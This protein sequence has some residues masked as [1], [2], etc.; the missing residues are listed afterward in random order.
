MVSSGYDNNDNNQRGLLFFF[1]HLI[2]SVY[3][4]KFTY[5]FFNETFKRCCKIKDMYST[6][7]Q[8]QII[9]WIVAKYFCCVIAIVH[10]VVLEQKNFWVFPLEQ[11]F[12]VFPKPTLV[13][14]LYYCFLPLSTAINVGDSWTW[15]RWGVAHCLHSTVALTLVLCIW[16]ALI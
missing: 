4:A 6:L 1:A 16:L 5:I 7:M 13:S 10:A 14:L 15:H 8:T 11:S 12:H 2:V 3:T 9:L